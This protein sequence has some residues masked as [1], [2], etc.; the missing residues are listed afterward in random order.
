M[1]VSSLLCINN[2][3]T[4]EGMADENEWKKF[5]VLL[6]QRLNSELFCKQS[7]LNACYNYNTFSILTIF[8]MKFF[9]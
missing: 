5:S 3:G 4:L 9:E 6:C 2:M 7:N 1:S 8:F